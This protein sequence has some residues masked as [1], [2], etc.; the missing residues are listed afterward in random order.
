M[1][2]KRIKKAQLQ[3]VAA[4]LGIESEGTKAELENRITAY[5]EDHTALESDSRYSSFFANIPK[6]KTTAPVESDASKGKKASS[7]TQ[8]IPTAPVVDA[9]SATPNGNHCVFCDRYGS[10]VFKNMCLCMRNYASNIV[11]I[12]G[13]L[14][15]F[16]ACNLGKI[17]VPW[18][19]WVRET[20]P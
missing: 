18:T 11:V 5:L 12:N 7:K 10:C 15:A 13:I 8:A 20:E 3:E 9:T 1:S 2:L 4:S 19:Y 6:Q 14:T 17:I 16:E